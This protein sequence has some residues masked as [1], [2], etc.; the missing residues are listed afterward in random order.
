MVTRQFIRLPVTVCRIVRR[1]SMMRV[2][3]WNLWLFDDGI[4]LLNSSSCTGLDVSTGV[5]VHEPA[6][7]KPIESVGVFALCKTSL[8]G[9]A[10]GYTSSIL[11]PKQVTRAGMIR[12][13]QRLLVVIRVSTCKLYTLHDNTDIHQFV[14]I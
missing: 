11:V 9:V 14:A 2:V 12:V 8:L 4:F 13:T 3:V 6:M 7:A 1:T 5:R 10:S